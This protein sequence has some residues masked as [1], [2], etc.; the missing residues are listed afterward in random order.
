MKT[1]LFKYADITNITIGQASKTDTRV[2]F[3]QGLHFLN[4]RLNF[5]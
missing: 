4:L 3:A 2:R 1:R 5:K